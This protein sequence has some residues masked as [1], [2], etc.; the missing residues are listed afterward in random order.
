MQNLVIF[1]IPPNRHHSLQIAT[2]FAPNRHVFWNHSWKK[3]TVA[4]PSVLK[5][6]RFKARRVQLLA[7][8]WAVCT[9]EAWQTGAWGE[10]LVPE[11]LLS[12]PFILVLIVLPWCNFGD[13]I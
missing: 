11:E 4:T 5:A 13:G 8:S 12:T 3:K 2:D 7:V 1:E 6:P 10:R 9:G